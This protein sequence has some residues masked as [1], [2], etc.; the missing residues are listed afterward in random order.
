MIRL[1]VVIKFGFL[2]EDGRESGER[3]VFGLFGVRG[4]VVVVGVEI[5]V[6]RAGE[7]VGIVFGDGAGPARGV[8]RVG[9]EEVVGGGSGGAAGGVAGGG[10]G[11]V[12]GGGGGRGEEEGADHGEAGGKVEGEELALVEEFVGGDETGGGFAGGKR[13]GEFEL[14]GRGGVGW[15]GR[16]GL[17]SGFNFVNIC[18]C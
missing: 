16:E 14:G 6:E 11:G 1:V 15:G 2:A 5:E 13:D 8:A 17:G 18:S 10:G 12:G 3:K 9:E 7:R 4:E